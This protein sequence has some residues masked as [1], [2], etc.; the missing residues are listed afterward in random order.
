M[1]GELSDISVAGLCVPPRLPHTLELSDELV[2]QMDESEFWRD[3]WLSMAPSQLLLTGAG[4]A[5]A[6]LVVCGCL[7]AVAEL[8]HFLLFACW[9]P[10]P[11]LTTW[12]PPPLL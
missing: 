4:A 3:L 12:P 10:P 11:P 8:K 5:L 7:A 6:P 2:E 1:F 9:P